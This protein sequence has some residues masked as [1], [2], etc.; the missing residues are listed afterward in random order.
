MTKKLLLNEW[1]EL[2]G[3]N[4]AKGTLKKLADKYGVPGGTVRR[5][6]SEHL[7]KNKTN[8]R[9]KKRT[10]AERSNERDIQVKKDI[11]SNIPKEEVMRK[12]EIS[13]ATYYR[14]EKNIRQLRLEKTEEQLDDILL[15]VYS[16]LGD[17]LKNVE[18]SKRN[19]VIRMAKEISKDE[20]LDAKRL[21][22]IDK[23]YVTIKKMGNDLMRTGKML[24]AYELLE[25][26][27]QL[28][29]EALQQ[30][31]LDIERSKLKTDINEDNKIEIKLVG[32]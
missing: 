6:K 32:I 28:A 10:N 1:E 24:T 8:V 3:E 11:L 7:K 31:K 25:V 5:W 18:I 4:A 29:E 9:N 12:N 13:N 2:G 27:K 16:D 21:Q 15:K 14:K 23:A 26:D 19:L 22:I 20:T 30:E 17:V